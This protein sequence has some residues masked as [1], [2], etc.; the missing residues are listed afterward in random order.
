M[1]RVMEEPID[2]QSDAITLRG[3]TH[4]LQWTNHRKTNITYQRLITR[5]TELTH[6]YLLQITPNLLHMSLSL[7]IP[8]TPPGMSYLLTTPLNGLSTTSTSSP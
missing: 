8:H 4:P 2:T 6:A 5:H 7:T 1:D 3:T